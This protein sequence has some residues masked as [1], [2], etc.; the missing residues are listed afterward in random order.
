MYTNYQVVTTSY[1]TST[2]FDIN[3]SWFGFSN[4]QIRWNKNHQQNDFAVG[5]TVAGNTTTVSVKAGSLVSF[6]TDQ[7]VYHDRPVGVYMA[8]APITAADL[9]GSG[10]IWFKILDIGLKYTGGTWDLGSA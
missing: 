2:W 1:L 7:T 3:R 9:D 4:F 5:N 8:K 6:T 10:D